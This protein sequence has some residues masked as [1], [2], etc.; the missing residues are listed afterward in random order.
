MTLEHDDPRHNEEKDSDGGETEVLSPSS[1]GHSDLFPSDGHE[2]I[3]DQPP[4]GSL[5]SE[6]RSSEVKPVDS[7]IAP[8]GGFEDIESV[9]SVKEVK[10]EDSSE[11]K[12]V[13]I[14][15]IQVEAVQVSA[16]GAQVK[17]YIVGLDNWSQVIEKKLEQEEVKAVALEASESNELVK[18]INS[19]PEGPAQVVE[20]SLVIDS[21][22]QVSSVSEKVVHVTETLIEESPADSLQALKDQDKKLIPL[23]DEASQALEA[24]PEVSS[25]NID[26]TVTVVTD[27]ND[28]KSLSDE[29]EV[30]LLVSQ[31]VSTAQASDMVKT[32]KDSERPAS[33]ENKVLIQSLT[34]HQTLVF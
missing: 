25:M 11:S 28:K 7:A 4:V 22:K 24:I 10:S 29:R 27:E 32:G 5:A 26:E 1:Q 33:S 21:V 6:S 14:E 2:H 19:L 15:C 17:N 12:T 34:Q 20:S 30:K 23:R 13:D 18:Q 16:N 3:E 8:K 9:E 31:E